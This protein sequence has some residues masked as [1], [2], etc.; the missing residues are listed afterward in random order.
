MPMRPVWHTTQH[1]QVVMKV[2]DRLKKWR[3]QDDSEWPLQ[4]S[5]SHRARSGSRG[6]CAPAHAPVHVRMYT[7]ACAC[8]CVCV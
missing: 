6:K 3:K 2:Q 7:C 1:P 8:V 5:L 4:R